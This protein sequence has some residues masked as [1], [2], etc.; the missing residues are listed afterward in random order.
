[1][2]TLTDQRKKSLMAYCRLD[3]LE[4]GDEALLQML[5]DTAVNYLTDA[6]I[7]E[8]PEGTPRRAQYDL[9]IN[10]LVDDGYDRRGAT[11]SDPALV[12]NRVFRQYL[13]Q[14]KQ[15]EPVPAS[16]P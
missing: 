15:T 5:Y 13:N 8:P 16:D 10:A 14:L 3:V 12:D 4:E 11:F 2:A 1:M 6:G 7:S 9:C